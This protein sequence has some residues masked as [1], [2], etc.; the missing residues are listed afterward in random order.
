VQEFDPTLGTIV[1]ARGLPLSNNVPNTTWSWD[2]T[3]WT[4]LRNDPATYSAV[5]TDPYHSQLVVLDTN[6]IVPQTVLWD[7]DRWTGI[8]RPSM[9]G[10]RAARMAWD[11]A[12]LRFVLFSGTVTADTWEWD[13]FSWLNRSPASSP[14]ARYLHATA[15]HAASGTVV[16]FGGQDPNGTALFNDTW[17]W[18]G[19][20][21]S[22]VTPIVGPIPPARR[23]HRMAASSNNA[24]LLF[25]GTDV[26]NVFSDTWTWNGS[27]WAPLSP[28][29]HPPARHGHA[30][31]L[32][33]SGA[34]RTA[35]G[36]GLTGLLADSWTWNGQDWLQSTSMASPLA[37]VELVTDP[38]RGSTLAVSYPG[39][40]N[41]IDI[42]VLTSQAAQ[43][44]PY[45]QGCS[46]SLGVP[47]LRASGRPAIGTS[48][49]R[50]HLGEVPAGSL[51]GVLVDVASASVP[52]G[53][54]TQLL[55]A[56][57]TLSLGVANEARFFGY[58]MPIPLGTNLIGA[59][60]YVQGA[61]ID[62]GGALLG[63]ASLTQGLQ[64][65][66]GI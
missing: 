36:V 10:P 42:D 23:E 60:F 7:G 32:E 28:Q 61:A 57:A 56:P 58:T 51:A 9:P 14:P 43:V 38:I 40:P 5:A 49:F 20:T 35:G 11:S 66:V 33:P 50:L 39:G 52:I 41:R 48:S 13:G 45:G 44:L 18:S 63:L 16:I 8:L 59:T 19:A 22:N 26:L 62:T 25:G 30:M 17:T 4:S 47:V 34:I 37:N 3:A 12:R 2:G 65:R 54:C 27:S 24:C 53:G 46:G 6:Y 64:V 29:H 1:V 31:L 55:L 15:Y 21:W